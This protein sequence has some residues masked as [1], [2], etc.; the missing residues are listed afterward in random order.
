M[1]E[2]TKIDKDYPCPNCGNTEWFH[3]MDSLADACVNCGYIRVGGDGEW[4][5]GKSLQ[6]WAK[7]IYEASEE[8][9]KTED[10]KH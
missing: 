8:K 3:M 1:S 5:K 6:E 10:G 9:G 7:D 2:Y 4:K